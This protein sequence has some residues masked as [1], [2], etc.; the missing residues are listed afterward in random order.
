MLQFAGCY[1]S[2]PFAF[3]V[4]RVPPCCA[5]GIVLHNQVDNV[6]FVKTRFHLTPV[7]DVFVFSAHTAQMEIIL[8][9]WLK[10]HLH[11][12]CKFLKTPNIV[13]S[14]CECNSYSMENLVRAV[15]QGKY[16]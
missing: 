3:L 13:F 4:S 2:K 15:L 16:F 10:L 7:L 9:T 11:S 5:E 6:F 12:F 14:A 8:S 1:L